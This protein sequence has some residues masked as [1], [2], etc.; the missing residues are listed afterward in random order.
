MYTRILLFIV[1]SLLIANLRL[2]AQILAVESTFNPGGTYY[3]IP[4]DSTYGWR[5]TV[6]AAPISVTHLGYFDV[7]LDGFSGPHQVGIWDTS[8]GLLV[9]A[10][11]PAGTDADLSG[12]YRFELVSTTPLSANTTYLIGA[13]TAEV[14]ADTAIAFAAPQAYASEIMYLGA[15]YNNSGFAAPSTGYSAAHGVFGPNFQFTSVPEPEEYAV[16]MGLGLVG[17]V[18]LR[19][20]RARRSAMRAA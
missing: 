15:S 20:C 3:S 14:N 4:A 17:F 18:C 12:A 6:G 8:G 7:G 16:L 10:A 13:Y 11:L 5:F 1:P 2:D 19:K 9:Q